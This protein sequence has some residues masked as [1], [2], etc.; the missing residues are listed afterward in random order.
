MPGGI[1]AQHGA[2]CPAGEMQEDF[3][4]EEATFTLE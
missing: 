3:L 1:E 4:E 2:L